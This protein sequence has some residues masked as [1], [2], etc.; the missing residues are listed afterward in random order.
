M[1]RALEGM[2]FTNVT[3]MP[4]C[5]ELKILKPGE[6]VYPEALPYKLCTFSR[7]MKEKGVEDAFKA[8]ETINGQYEKTVFTL[9]IYGQIEPGQE[10][11]FDKLKDSFSSTVHY[12]GVVPFDQSTDVLKYYYA[13]L[14]PTYYAGEGFAGTLIDAMAA[15]VPVIASDWK[16]NPEIVQSGIT[17]IVYELANEDGL[18][19]AL[20]YA[21]E[22]HTE[23]NRMKLSSIEE[24]TRYL[25]QNATKIL[26]KE[27][28]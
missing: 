1:K 22:H 25:T 27:L 4:N 2:D 16:Y 19:T 24:S 15:G 26:I 10:E 14:F 5:K 12:G 18:A 20:K 11:W 7:V 13:L 17:G 6:I 8:V 3:V 28:A 23:W 21:L 9:D